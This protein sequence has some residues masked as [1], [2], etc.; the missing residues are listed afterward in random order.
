MPVPDECKMPDLSNLD[1]PL[2]LH[3]Y[4]QLLAGENRAFGRKMNLYHRNFIRLTDKALREYGQAREAILAEITER[5]LTTEEILKQGQH[6]I[7]YTFTD[8]IETCIN[9]LSRLFRI[10]NRIKSEQTSPAFPRQLRKLAEATNE[11][12]SY[13]RNAVEHMDE[14]IQRDEIAAG[15]PI[16]L[17][18]SKD[19]DY[20][21]ASKHKISFS[22][23][24]TSL[25]AMHEIA[26]YLVS[27]RD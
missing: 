1:L 12:I 6:L 18:A 25:T 16:M 26:L 20:L 21:V 11:K 7:G 17:D 9:A 24:A 23:L 8:H 2:I 15:R 14:R 13:L 3:L 27:A 22:E 5:N 19:G 4:T 10:L